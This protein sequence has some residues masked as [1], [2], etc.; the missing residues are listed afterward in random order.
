M[1]SEETQGLI[2]VL[3]IEELD[4]NDSESEHTDKDTYPTDL[5]GNGLELVL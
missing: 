4:S 1:N 2:V 5:V 3:I